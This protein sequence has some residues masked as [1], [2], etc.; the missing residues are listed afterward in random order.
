MFRV[1]F[2]NADYFADLMKA[3]N[4][5]I[6]EATFNLH[7]EALSLVAMDP[8]HIVAVKLHISPSSAEQ[9]ECPEPTKFSVNIN[10]LVKALKRAKKTD[11]LVLELKDNQ[12]YVRLVNLSSNDEREY[13]LNTLDLP[14]SNFQLPELSFQASATLDSSMFYNI[15][16]DAS[17][18]SDY[19]RIFITPDGF[20]LVAKGD[21]GK[22]EARLERGGTVCWEV[23]TESE[24]SASFSLTYLEKIVK[25]VKNVG[26]AIRIYLSQNKPVKLDYLGSGVGL[27]YLVAPRVE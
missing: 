21:L 20:R 14:D 19:A 27:T 7:P 25:A 26:E 23:D 12:L 11:N 8:A 13:V 9:Y 18:V 22:Y 17:N 5:I 10:D 24:V 4:S 3:I 15:V 1:V 2:P 6:E 16:D